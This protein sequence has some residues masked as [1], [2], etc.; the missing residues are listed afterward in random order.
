MQWVQGVL[1]LGVKWPVHE[2]DHPHTSSAEVKNA[3]S[4]TSTP[5]TPSWCGAQL[6][7]RDNFTFTFTFTFTFSYIILVGFVIVNSGTS[8]AVTFLETC[9]GQALVQNWDQFI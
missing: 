6:K 5:N 3:W 9:L 7:H 1:S 2:A 8:H 4:C